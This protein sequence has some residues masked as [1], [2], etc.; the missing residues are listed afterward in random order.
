[1]VEFLKR[2]HEKKV[3]GE[4]DRA[5][6]VRIS[7]EKARIRLGRLVC[8]PVFVPVDSHD[9]RVVAVKL[10]KCANAIR[11]QK[12]SLV[13]HYAQH[14][15]QPLW[16]D[17]G[18]KS[19]RSPL[20]IGDCSYVVAQ[21][22]PIFDKPEHASSKSGQ[23]IGNFRLK[24]FHREQWNKT[25][26]RSNFEKMMIVFR[27]MQYVIKKSVFLVPEL[28]ALTA[29]VVHRFGDIDKVFKELARHIAVRVVFS[30]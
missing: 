15:R 25:D 12:L 10:R 7:S 26:H 29:T 23:C 14:S 9:I 5:A 24:S 16:T 27:E 17:N 28:D 18:E 1:M 21:F 6:P 20:L 3:Q 8:D 13:Q 30:C 22:R 2:L 19:P 11:R 4:P